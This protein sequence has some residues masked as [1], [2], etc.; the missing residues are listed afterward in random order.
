M[1][2]TTN[3]TVLIGIDGGAG[4]GKTTF[5][6]W[7]ADQIKKYAAPVSIVLTD[8]I[9]RPTADR[10]AGAV[11]DMPIGYDLDWERIRDEVILPLSSGRTAQFQ[12]Y[13]WVKDRLNEMVNIEPGGVTIIDG[14]FALRKELVDYY[15][16]RLWFSCPLEVR[17]ARLL[18]RGDTPQ[19]EIDYWLPIE[20]RYHEE[21]KPEKSADL[22]INSETN[23]TTII[24]RI[25]QQ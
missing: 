16:L 19:S 12:L 17:V 21:H 14:V 10:W 18:Q 11:E 9:Y 24:N 1:L 7:F 4:A 13:D 8:L 25:G 20:K 6:R 5:T 22:V 15:D 2:S 3:Q 23:E